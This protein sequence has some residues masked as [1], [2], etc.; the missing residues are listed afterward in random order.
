MRD[1][2][3]F[4]GRIH[5]ER[6]AVRMEDA[7]RLQHRGLYDEIDME[8]FIHGSHVLV[9]VDAP[10]EVDN[11]ATLRNAVQSS[12]SSVTDP[13]AFILGQ[14]VDVEVFACITPSGYKRVFGVKHDYISDKIDQEKEIR[15]WFS[16]IMNAYQTGA[17]PFIQRC[18][19]DFRLAMNHPEDTGFYCYRAVESLRQFF[20]DGSNSDDDES[21]E[22][23]RGAISFDRDT[24]EEDIKAY[25]DPRRHGEPFS[26]TG[27][28]RQLVLETTWE[29]IREFIEYSN[30]ELSSVPD[31]T[32][33]KD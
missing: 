15:N 10:E 21:W 5:P 8:L 9:D 30:K 4:F 1:T 22:E 14:H 33:E 23:L 26:I 7:V 6:A 27:E 13:L 17:S 24:I 28:E 29:I 16:K 18:F 19:T 3:A 20:K 31:H 2:Y 32:A 25:A 11:L 12:V